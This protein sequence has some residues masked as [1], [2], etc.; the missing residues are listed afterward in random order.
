MLTATTRTCN[1][2]QVSGDPRGFDL[3]G[4][5]ERWEQAGGDEISEANEFPT[6]RGFYI[7]QKKLE[8]FAGLG[9]AVLGACASTHGG[10]RSRSSSRG[11][12]CARSCVVT[13]TVQLPWP[14][15]PTLYPS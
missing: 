6:V 10:G 1:N 13:L 7:L 8:G 9:W 14:L 15:Y 4:D 12:H 2:W 11:V 3:T 5:G